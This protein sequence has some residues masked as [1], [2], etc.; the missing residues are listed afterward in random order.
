MD[1]ARK[2]FPFALKGSLR[3]LLCLVLC[4]VPVW[5][6]Q[7]PAS[8]ET[9]TGAVEP[10]QPQSVGSLQQPVPQEPGRI[11]GK[12]VDQ[13]G[14]NITGATITLARDGQSS[15]QQAVS[16]EEG[17]FYFFNVPP[18]PFHLAISSPGL[19]PQE[20]SATLQPGDSLVTPLFMLVVATQ[21]TQV[22]VALTP[23][24]VATE[25]IKEQEKQRVFGVIPNFFVSYVPDAAP[26]KPKHKFELAWKSSTDPFTFVAVGAI[27]GAFQAGDRWSGY[28]QGAEGYAKR[29]GA[30]YA[31]VFVGTYMGG[32]VFPTILKQDPRY[33]YRGKGSKASRFFYAAASSVICKGD[34][35]HWQPNYSNVLGN[36]AAGGIA[37]LYYPASSRHGASLVFSTALIRLGEVTIANIFQEF[38]V[39]KLTPN[40]PTRAPAQP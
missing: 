2:N 10:S 22:T 36:L 39:P 17:K 14:A 9:K 3:L 30:A 25:Q 35:G 21:V 32:A 4:S 33:Y 12:V 38:L 40:L 24:Q 11:S 34:N 27:A 23:E 13:T 28:G 37:N 15:T 8:P 18:G 6:Q 19:A 26:L 5:S 1:V 29:F 7:N 31:D 16:D 20:F